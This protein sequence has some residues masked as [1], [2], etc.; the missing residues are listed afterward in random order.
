MILAHGYFYES[1]DFGY[2]LANYFDY[3]NITV[4][5][6]DSNGD[7]DTDD[8]AYYDGND[9]HVFFQTEVGTQTVDITSITTPDYAFTLTGGSVQDI[10]I[11][12]DDSINGR[13]T[14]DFNGSSTIALSFEDTLRVVGEAEITAADLRNVSGLE[15]IELSAGNS[16]QAVTWGVELTDRVINQT[17]GSATLVISV[18]ANTPAG[19]VLYITLDPSIDAANN[20]VVIEKN[21]NVHGVHQ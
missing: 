12:D 16:S 17:T 8:I 15:R 5:F 19:S 11:A 14:L 9:D 3:Y 7:G 21:S 13:M 18:D 1:D 4:D 6:A 20:N 10:V 2:S